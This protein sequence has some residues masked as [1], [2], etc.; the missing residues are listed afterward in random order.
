M[1]SRP[2][3]Q[4][5]RAGVRAAALASLLV[6]AVGLPP[7]AAHAAPPAGL[8]PLD[9]GELSSVSG[10]DGISFN[11]SGFSIAPTAGR[12]T[13]LTY[14]MPGSTALDP[15]TLTLSN[16]SL[17]RT[18][19]A[20]PFTDPYILNIIPQG[21]GLPDKIRLSF[22]QNTNLTQLWNFDTDLSVT[23]P[24]LALGQP[25]VTHDLGNLQLN[26][27]AFQGGW[28]D[29]APPSDA[30]TQGIAFGLSTKIS[31][32]SLVLRP[33]GLADN[34]EMLSIS[35]VKIASKL[36]GLWSLSDLSTQPGLFNADT[37]ASGNAALHLQIG[38]QRSTDQAV[39]DASTA[40]ISINSIVFTSGGTTTDL[41]SSHIGGLQINFMDVRFRPGT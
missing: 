37:D 28:L 20:S 6:A 16:F 41:G 15:Y 22:P 11:L 3:R 14:A 17:S 35:G 30:N 4:V 13:T 34:T 9:D 39:I 32:D 18:D 31:L 25:P 29:V 12:T 23:T 38:W 24:P 2:P 36:G 1:S 40:S 7:C 10:G 8:K 5:R 26:N 27:L 21:T 19:D 33:R